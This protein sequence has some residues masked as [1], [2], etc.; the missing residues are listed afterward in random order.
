MF[1]HNTDSNVQVA[2]M[3]NSYF[4]LTLSLILLMGGAGCKEPS[5]SR[6]P[7]GVLSLGA[8]EASDTIERVVAP[9]VRN[10][11]LEGHTGNIY[12]TATDAN[13]ARLSVTRRTRADTPEEAEQ[14]LQRL[15]VEEEGNETAFRYRFA[16]DSPETSRF[17]IVG[18]IPRATP[19]VVNWRSGVVS[20]ESFA[21]SVEVRTVNGDIEFHGSSPR[22]AVHTRN[23]D[24]SATIESAPQTTAPRSNMEFV[25]ANGDVTALIPA[26]ANVRLEATT[27]AGTIRAGALPFSSEKFSVVGA[28]ARFHARLG[29]GSG[30]VKLATQHG[31]IVVG[32]FEAAATE[33]AAPGAP[34]DTTAADS[35]GTPPRLPDPETVDEQPAAPSAVEKADTVIAS[36]K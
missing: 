4:V 17:D 20:V 14:K 35:V 8:H 19:V 21:E 31:S 33:D 26:N 1:T 7:E 9:G 16:A 32:R 29:D 36:S 3:R 2:T 18:E 30:L 28:G 13:V 24:I 25:S 11:I 27:S 15:N 22:I 23:G 10:L 5:L 34:S 12:L 6:S